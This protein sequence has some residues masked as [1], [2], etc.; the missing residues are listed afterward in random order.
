MLGVERENLPINSFRFGQS[1]GAVVPE[2][3]LQRVLI[4]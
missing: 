2:S 4:G 1:P 3:F